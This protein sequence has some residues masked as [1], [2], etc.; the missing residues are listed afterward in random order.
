M[1]K[2]K[3]RTNKQFYISI[4]GKKVSPRKVCTNCKRLIP[5]GKGLCSEC[6]KIKLLGG[7]VKE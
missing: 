3:K 1:T 4:N 7:K 6:F 5:L 2:K